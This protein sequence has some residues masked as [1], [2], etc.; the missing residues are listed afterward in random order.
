MEQLKLHWTK[1]AGRQF[2]ALSTNI[3]KKIECIRIDCEYAELAGRISHRIALTPDP[4][5]IFWVE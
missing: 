2:I 1:C 3:G 5:I 4:Q